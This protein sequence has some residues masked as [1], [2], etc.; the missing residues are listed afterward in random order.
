ML[1]EPDLL[2]VVHMLMTSPP[3]SIDTVLLSIHCPMRKYRFTYSA[4]EKIEQ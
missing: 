3:V 1:V 2:K 4:N